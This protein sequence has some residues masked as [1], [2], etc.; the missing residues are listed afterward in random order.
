MYW[1]IVALGFFNLSIIAAAVGRPVT[2]LFSPDGIVGIA[3]LS[4]HQRYELQSDSGSGS[5]IILALSL[6]L[7]FRIGTVADRFP[8]VLRAVGALPIVL[9]SLVTT[10]KWPMFLAGVFF[11]AGI[12]IGFP[13]RTALRMAAWHL[14]VVAPVGLLVG[15]LAMVLRGSTLTQIESDLIHYVLAPYAAFGSWL[16][17]GSGTDC[18]ALGMRSLVGPLD[19]VGATVRGVGGG[20][21]DNSILIHGQLTNIYTAFRYVVEDFSVIGPF[22]IACWFSAT[23]FGLTMLGSTALARQLSAFTV[24]AALLSVSVTPFVHNSVAFAVSLSLA[25]TLARAIRLPPPPA[26]THPARGERAWEEEEELL[27][28]HSGVSNS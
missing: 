6:W 11:F 9:Y 4:T 28:Q 22:L 17:A 18:C 14:A 3:A 26:L 1:S 2:D 7:V 15:G 16:I 21:G 10:E 8:V 25:S 27:H 12:F 5:P 19:A 23:H 13:N 20:V 24:F